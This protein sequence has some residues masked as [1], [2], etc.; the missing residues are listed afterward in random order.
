MHSE[1]WTDTMQ[2]CENGHKITDH[3]VLWPQGRR[4]RCPDCGAVTLMKC[5]SCQADIHGGEVVMGVG[6]NSDTLPPAHCHQCGEAYPWKE[7]VAIR[8]AEAKKRA[9]EMAKEK[10]LQKTGG[11]SYNIGPIGT[12]ANSPLMMGSPGAS[13]TVTV[14]FTTDSADDLKVLIK[15][16]LDS[17]DELGLS[18]P[19]KETVKDDAEYLKKKLDGGKA[20]PGL[21]RECLNGIKKKLADAAA[22]AASSQIV[23]KAGHY[24]GLIG[25]FIAANF[26]G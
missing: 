15:S 22:T 24:L 3:A 9:E 5:P 17:L 18:A 1:S 23:T 8:D 7:K 25:D 14:T 6:Y 19:D 4:N 13:Q 26:G 20:E 16:L 12:I 10:E 21:V 11:N 2:V